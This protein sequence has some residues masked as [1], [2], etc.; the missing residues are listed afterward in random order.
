MLPIAD[1]P[2]RR[3]L[4]K[5]MQKRKLDPGCGNCIHLKASQRHTRDFAFWRDRILVA[6]EV[7]DEHQPKGIL[8][9]WRDDRNQVQWWTFWIAIILFALTIITCVEGALQV[10][11]AYHP[12]S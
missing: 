2:A 1:K 5:E 12:S 4:K 11:K 9:V 3:W 10:Y 8:Q 6:K 7:F